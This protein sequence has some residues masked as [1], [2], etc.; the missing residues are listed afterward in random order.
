MKTSSLKIREKK[1]G[2]YSILVN[3]VDI[4]PNATRAILNFEAGAAPELILSFPVTDSI[5]VELPDVAVMAKPAA[6]EKEGV[7]DEEK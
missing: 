5:D 4:A 7:E 3:G 1:P 2:V 6:A